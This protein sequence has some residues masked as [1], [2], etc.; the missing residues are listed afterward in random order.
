M[1]TDKSIVIK[2]GG[3]LIEHAPG[4]IRV[5]RDTCRDALIIPGGGL[6]ADLVRQRNVSDTTAHFMAIAAMDQYGWLLS[7]YGIPVTRSPA[8]C[9]F[10]HILLPYTHI[11]KTDPL[12]HSWDITSDTISAYYACLL[13][14]P[15]IILKSL[16]YIRTTEGP[17]RTLTDGMITDDLDPAFIPY[18]F[19]QGINGQI[20]LGSDL[21]KLA[22]L[23]IG[24]RVEGT[25]FG[26]TI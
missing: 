16:E 22:G 21:Q 26:S 11:L 25:R 8:F 5:I 9:G 20:I 7:D 18:V 2:I 12:P 24:D 6:F 15:L 3:S 13:S 23:L 1:H 14:T 4:I 19:S 10:P 17:V